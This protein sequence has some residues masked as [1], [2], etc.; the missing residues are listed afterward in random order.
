PL[1]NRN[2]SLGQPRLLVLSI[3][4]FAAALGA[5]LM[6][7][8][9]AAVA[10]SLAAVVSLMV[11]V[12]TLAEGYQ[13]VDGSIIVLLG[14]MLPVGQALETSGG[15]ELVA[16]SLLELGGQWPPVVTLIGLF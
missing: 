10:L 2:L 15:A 12:L 13:A 11:G 9:P 3:A 14:A 1:A 7:W 4:I 16:Q 8:V 6:G 5:M